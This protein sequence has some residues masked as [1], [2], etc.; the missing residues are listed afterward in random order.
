MTTPNLS[1]V[2]DSPMPR[3]RRRRPMHPDLLAAIY[4]AMDAGWGNFVQAKRWVL[5]NGGAARCRSER[6]A[7]EA[8]RARQEAIVADWNRRC[9]I[10]TWVGVRFVID[11]PEFMSAQTRSEA[12][13]TVNGATVMVHGR[14]GGWGI[15]WLRPLASA[16]AQKGAAA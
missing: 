14:A 11:E 16:S 13:M 10:G 5:A 15:A 1:A 9:P 7:R 8:E 2:P 3:K 4:R 6:E 12:Y